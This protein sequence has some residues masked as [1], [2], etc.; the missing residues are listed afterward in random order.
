MRSL[1]LPYL[2]R[3]ALLTTA[4]VVF[5]WS[6]AGGYRQLAAL[7][8]GPIAERGVAIW[9]LADSATELDLLAQR[10]RATPA[11]QLGS[12]GWRQR[13]DRVL[14]KLRRERTGTSPSLARLGVAI[15]AFHTRWGRFSDSAGTPVDELSS[16]AVADDL[17]TIASTLRQHMRELVRE[18]AEGRNDV[19]VRLSDGH[20]ANLFTL[21]GVLLS[22]T[23]LIGLLMDEGKKTRE[24]LLRAQRARAQAEQARSDLKAVTDAV[25]AMISAADPEGKLSFFNQHHGTFFGLDRSVPSADTR[26]DGEQVRVIRTV[27]ESGRPVDYFEER[28]SDHDGQAKDLLTT[29]VPVADATGKTREVV[30][31]S[32]DVTERKQTEAQLRHLAGHDPLTDLPNR[33]LFRGRLADV[34][35]LVQRRGSTAAVFRLD[36][37]HFGEV[38]ERYGQ[39]SADALL[40][41][42]ARRLKIALRNG[43]MLARLGS[44]QFAIIQSES[45]T[46]AATAPLAQRLLDALAKPIDHRGNKV[47]LSASIG[48]AVFP[49]DGN[50]PDSL[51]R[52]AEVA[53]ART[54]ANERGS[55]RFYVAE[56]HASLKNRRDLERALEGAVDRG[57][58]E[59]H[60]QPKVRASDRLITGAEALLRWNHPERGPLGPSSFIPLAEST[61]LIS[62]IG[63][64]AVEQAASQTVRWIEQTGHPLIVAVNLSPVQCRQSDLVSIIENSL[65]R[66]GLPATQLELEVTE[67]VLLDQN[68]GAVAKL[69]ELRRRGI[70]IA[71]DDFG[72]GYA[73]LSYLQ[74]FEFDCI[75]IDRSFV[76]NI[77]PEAAND[78]IVRAVLSLAQSLSIKVV[79]EGVQ[80]ETQFDHLRS[81]G[82][83]EFQG[84]LLGRPEPARIFEQLYLARWLAAEGKRDG[85]TPGAVGT[86]ERTTAPV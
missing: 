72:T 47:Q 65:E 75:K 14:A 12:V 19:M 21:S 9:Q 16:A 73:S 61:G 60:Y 13:T 67:G 52:H 70:R 85:E 11:D 84:Y 34:L 28:R 38:N 31:V 4:L 10:I 51:I 17:V 58:L 54:K 74:Q 33:V 41:A 66:T 25:P 46:T 43:D 8:P 5:V 37:D 36:I 71:L 80:T 3:L 76:E 53:L 24:L 69:R 50:D 56:M 42:V 48:I 44:D 30:T 26:L 35:R 32:L 23:I 2:T 82:C 15:D 62:R 68:A 57:E 27:F 59:L 1:D 81:L 64:W 63:A 6:I 20:R 29:H 22:G 78:K 55:Y 40:V 18:I 49:G 83:N 86:T 79:A 7:D 45:E 77:S 39:S